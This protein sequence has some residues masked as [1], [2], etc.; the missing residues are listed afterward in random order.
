MMN[1]TS[2]SRAEGV[3]RGVFWRNPQKDEQMHRAVQDAGFPFV[4]TDFPDEALRRIEEHDWLKMTDPAYE[5]MHTTT[6][7]MQFRRA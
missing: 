3:V 5:G 1:A 7:C 6:E 2:P 4:R